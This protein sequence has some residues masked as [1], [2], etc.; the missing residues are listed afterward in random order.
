MLAKYGHFKDEARDS[1]T[2]FL[3]VQTGNDISYKKETK[4]L[5]SMNRVTVFHFCDT[6]SL[7]ASCIENISYLAGHL[8]TAVLVE[9]H[10]S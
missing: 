2:L 4:H 8:C 1:D 10:F 3:K 7:K 6:G 5:N 9:T